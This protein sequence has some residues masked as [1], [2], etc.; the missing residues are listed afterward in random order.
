MRVLPI[1]RTRSHGTGDA[2][3]DPIRLLLEAIVAACLVGI[4]CWFEEAWRAV[5]GR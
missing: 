3:T 1:A 5:K 2:M 4:A